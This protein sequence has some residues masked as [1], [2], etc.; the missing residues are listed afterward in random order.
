MAMVGLSTG[1]KRFAWRAGGATIGLILVALLIGYTPHATRLVDTRT[2]AEAAAA[3]VVPSGATVSGAADERSLVAVQ[4]ASG[5]AAG[6]PVV[7]STGKMAVA[8]FPGVIKVAFGTALGNIVY[9]YGA[10]DA[11]GN[12]THLV[13]AGLEGPLVQDGGTVAA[14]TP[15]GLASQPYRLERWT[16]SGPAD[17]T[18]HAARTCQLAGPGVSK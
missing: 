5:G 14:G 4:V 1:G 3:A 17:P 8:A 13:Y 2:R 11:A 9:L 18:Q 15:L 7:T 6:A 10:G 12:A 16:C